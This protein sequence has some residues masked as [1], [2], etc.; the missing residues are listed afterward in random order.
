MTD[1]RSCNSSLT[2]A[3]TLGLGQTATILLQVQH[4]RGRHSSELHQE[5][6]DLMLMVW[7]LLYLR[8]P[9][10]SNTLQYKWINMLIYFVANWY[11]HQSPPTFKSLT[12]VQGSKNVHPRTLPPHRLRQARTAPN[13]AIPRHLGNS[14][15]HLGLHN[16]HN[17]RTHPPHPASHPRMPP[18]D[19]P[20]VQV[21]S[22]LPVSAAWDVEQMPIMC[23]DGATFMHAQGGINVFTDFVLLL[24]PLPLLRLLKFNKRQ[25]S[26]S[27]LGE[28]EGAQYY[29]ATETNNEQWRCSSSS[30][31]A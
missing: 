22:C 14:I 4:G 2:E 3:K 30:Q 5:D 24:Y 23:I 9:L 29:L 18:A 10:R 16:R 26:K 6:F 11:V 17:P 31:S 20:Q 27:G 21:F 13:R 8:L 7:M 25:R 1:F 28:D 19:T 15:L 12:C